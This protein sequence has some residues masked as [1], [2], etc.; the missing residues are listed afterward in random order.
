VLVAVTLWMFIH[1][2]LVKVERVKSFVEDGL[3]MLKGLHDT[4]LG[5]SV[6][7]LLPLFESIHQVIMLRN[8]FITLA[9]DFFLH[10]RNLLWAHMFRDTSEAIAN[11]LTA[12]TDGA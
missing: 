6:R 5:L 4:Q 11:L 3:S 9:A 2:R 12:R 8:E 7:V 10:V 1:Q